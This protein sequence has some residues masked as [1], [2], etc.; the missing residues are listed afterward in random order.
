MSRHPADHDDE[1][2]SPSALD[3]FDFDRLP[4]R[5]RNACLPKH[6]RLQ[7]SETRRDILK[8]VQQQDAYIVEDDIYGV[9]AT[10]VR[11]GCADVEGLS[12][13]QVA[14]S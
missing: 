6:L 13:F 9:Y 2:I 1:G 8:A 10:K 12:G 3:Q 5:L 4:H 7:V 14:A 11:L